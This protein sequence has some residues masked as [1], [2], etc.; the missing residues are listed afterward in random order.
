MC[1]HHHHHFS[2][3]QT[4]AHVKSATFQV[5]LKSFDMAVYSC[6]KACLPLFLPIHPHPRRR[7]IC[8]RYGLSASWNTSG[9]LSTEERETRMLAKEKGIDGLRGKKTTPFG[10][11]LV[12]HTESNQRIICSLSEAIVT[13]ER[14]RVHCSQLYN[15]TL[16]RLVHFFIV[17]STRVVS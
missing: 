8:Y 2:S 5:C 13:V 15:G 14:G 16:H 17:K 12:C 7:I 11:T 9:Q 6:K 10:Y 3:H 4:S 1:L